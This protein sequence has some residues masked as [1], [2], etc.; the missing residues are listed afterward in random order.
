MEKG[1][2]SSVPTANDLWEADRSVVGVS[3]RVR[4]VLARASPV[5]SRPRR[6]GRG[7]RGSAVAV[8][9]RRPTVTAARSETTPSR[10]RR[11]TSPRASSS[12][13]STARRCGPPATRC[14]SRSASAARVRAARS[15]ARAGRARA[16]LRGL[17]VAVRH[18]RRQP[19]DRGRR[20]HDDGARTGTEQGRGWRPWS[21][22]RRRTPTPWPS[23]AR[24]PT[25]TTSTPSATSGRSRPTSRSGARPGAPTARSASRAWTPCTGWSC[26]PRFVP[27]DVGGPLT[28]QALARGHVD[29]AL[30]FT[31][32]PGIAADDLVVLADDMALQP[33][34][35][36]T[37]VVGGT[38]VDRW[39]PPVVDVVDAVF[40]AP[41]DS[42]PAGAEHAGWRR[43]TRHRRW[44][45]TGCGRRA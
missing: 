22:R 6:G 28:H 31:T 45:P 16:R 36:V 18:P 5:V 19:A 41:D 24:W 21:R 2:A 3:R 35:N 13:R 33:A 34:E 38:V 14:G 32:D 29:V 44:R 17:C 25:G 10:S 15:G 1:T 9:S 20:R 11:S 7:S 39:G 23:P 37:P 40:G 4:G 26:A 12:Q 42:R 43:A 27:L 30:L 8:R